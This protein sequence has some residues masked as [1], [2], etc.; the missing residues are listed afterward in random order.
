[1]LPLTMGLSSDQHTA[2]LWSHERMSR[3]PKAPTN[4]ARIQR[5]LGWPARGHSDQSKRCDPSS[6]THT[7]SRGHTFSLVITHTS[8]RYVTSP[9]PSSPILFLSAP[10]LPQLPAQKEPCVRPESK[11]LPGF[12]APV[13]TPS[14]RQASRSSSVTLMSPLGDFDR[15]LPLLTRTHFPR[16][17]H[18]RTL[19]SWSLEDLV[20]KPHHLL[21]LKRDFNS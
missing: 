14:H 6:S 3:K 15:C 21:L 4:T 1:M 18:F 11:P 13:A 20:E 7:H 10:P 12:L 2:G 16:K 8:L 9:S 17:P 5:L 19:S